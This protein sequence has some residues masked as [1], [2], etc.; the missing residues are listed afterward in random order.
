MELVEGKGTSRSGGASHVSYDQR[1]N[2]K[3]NE[4]FAEGAELAQ[5]WSISLLP[6]LET[7]TLSLLHLS[8]R[9][10]MF[11]RFLFSLP[12]LFL[13]RMCTGRSPCLYW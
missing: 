2:W 7:L 9:P 11:L 8:C 6:I 10:Y 3:M 1:G 5:E 12:L 4:T 13:H